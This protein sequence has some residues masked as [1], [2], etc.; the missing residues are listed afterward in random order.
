MASTATAAAEAWGLLHE[1]LFSQRRRFVAIAAEFELH[2]AQSGALLQLEAQR[3]M[4]MNELAT[5]LQCDNS[6]VTG[7]VDRLEA[8]GLVERRLDA[9]DRRIKRVL[10]TTAGSALR[11]RIRERMAEPPPELKRMSA[12]DQRAL[13]DLLRRALADD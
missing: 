3:P 12:V 10:L 2:P 4:P 9:H 7:I 13:R 1:L 8:R 11:E 5:L 6:N